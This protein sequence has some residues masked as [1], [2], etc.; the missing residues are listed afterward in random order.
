[1]FRE[2]LHANNATLGFL[3][4]IQEAMEE[5]RPVSAARVRRLVAGVTTQTYRMVSNLNR[6]TGDRYR[7]V[8]TRFHDVKVRVARKV[9][10]TPTLAQL[11]RFDTVRDR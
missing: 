5:E 2:V 3:A 9:E 8:L 10:L 7:T 6:M 1:M 4:G 11:S